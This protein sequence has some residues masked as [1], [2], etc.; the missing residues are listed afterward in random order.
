VLDM[1]VGP[2]ARAYEMAG[3]NPSP[4]TSTATSRLLIQPV[5]IRE[6]RLLDQT[7]DPRGPELIR[8]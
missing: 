2:L 4:T 1:A 7:T 3:H 5:R 8:R 6:S